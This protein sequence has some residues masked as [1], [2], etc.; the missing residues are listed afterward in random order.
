MMCGN[1]CH[2]G[3]TG[4]FLTGMAAGIA[5]GAALGAVMAPSSR[6]IKRAAH[7]AAR[8]VNDAVDHGYV[9]EPGPAPAPVFRTG[10]GRWGLHRAGP[11]WYD[12]GSKRRWRYAAD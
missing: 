1:S 10:A 5:A 3:G 2:S 9:T 4:H 8:R 11:V 6:Q 7:R 12:G